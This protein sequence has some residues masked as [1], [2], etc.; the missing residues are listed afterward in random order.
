MIAENQVILV[1]PG[2]RVPLDLEIL[3]GQASFDESSLTGEAVPVTKAVS[4]TV[5]EGAVNLDGV[6]TARVIHTLDDSA[7]SQMMATMAEAQAT[8]P[9]IQ[10]LRTAF[11]PF[12]CQPY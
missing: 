8:K 6:I 5:L 12:L 4:Q 3:S 9:E 1:K 11:Q 10:K 7:I 2:E